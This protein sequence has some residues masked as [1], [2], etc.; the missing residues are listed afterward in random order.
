[1]PPKKKPPKTREEILEQKRTAERLRYQRLQNDP[2]KR[3]E[4]KEKERRKYQ[5]K[6][7][8]GTRKNRFS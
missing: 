8:K 3:E 6:K 5:K 4:M 1:M 7:E 2:H